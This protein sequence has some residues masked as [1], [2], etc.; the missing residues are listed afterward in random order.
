M[1]APD[2]TGLTVIILAPAHAH[3][4]R[5]LIIEELDR[6]QVLKMTTPRAHSGYQ[7]ML[8]DCASDLSDVYEQIV[9]AKSA[10]TVGV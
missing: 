7:G 2:K 5:L 6:L 8:D 3:R 4:L 9:T 10:I 1:D